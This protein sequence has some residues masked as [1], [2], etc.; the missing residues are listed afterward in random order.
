MSKLSH[1]DD[2]GRASMVDVSEKSTTERMASAEATIVLSEEAFRLVVAGEN[3]KGDVLATAR[4]SH[5]REREDHGS[6]RSRDGRVDGRRGG[7]A[8]HLRYGEGGRQKR[9]RRKHP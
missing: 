9:S 3:K 7:R 4:F 6:N 8:D 2:Q 1:L 5:S